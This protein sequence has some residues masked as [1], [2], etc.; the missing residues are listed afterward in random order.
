MMEECPCCG[1]FFCPFTNIGP[2]VKMP[3]GTIKQF[4]RECGD[5]Q[6]PNWRNE[7]DE[8]KN[9]DCFQRS[10]FKIEES[11]KPWNINDSKCR[12]ASIFLSFVW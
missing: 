7:D 8:W 3:D 6:F 9:I 11:K 10:S 2:L 12:I 1:L 5:E 4:C